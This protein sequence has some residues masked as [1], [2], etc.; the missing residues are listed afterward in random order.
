MRTRDHGVTGEYIKAMKAE[1][2]TGATLEEFVRLRDHGVTQEYIQDMKQAGFTSATVED[3]VRAR[4]H[5]V[6]PEYVQ[7]IRA[8][9]AAASRRSSSSSGCATT[10]SPSSTCKALE[11]QGFKNVPVED[12]V[13]DEGPR[14]QRRS[15][16]P[17]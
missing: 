16:S 8:P 12:I 10:A 15:T 9:R 17:T 5:G 13:R 4:D 14:R 6:K 7:E 1:G 3:L 2:F 11:A